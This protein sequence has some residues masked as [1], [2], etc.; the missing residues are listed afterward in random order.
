MGYVMKDNITTHSSDDE[1]FVIQ[2]DGRVKSLHR[3]FLDALRVG[4]LL[5]EQ[6]PLHCVK[7]CSA[8]ARTVRREVMQ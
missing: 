6:F 4:L 8:Q 7:V 1:Y 5:R 3:R 2:I